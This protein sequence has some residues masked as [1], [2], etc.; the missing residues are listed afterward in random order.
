MARRVA[1][2]TGGGR[3]LGRAIAHALAKD[4]MAVAVGA[5]S[6]DQIDD[7]ASELRAH[8]HATL[9]VPL[10]VTDAGSNTAAVAAVIRALGPIDIL[11]NTA[12]IAESAPFGRTTGCK[13]SST[14]VRANWPSRRARLWWPAP[15]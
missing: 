8:G 10:D 2:V 5:R 13:Y 14:S 3:G 4:G 1:L 12:G 7:V 9:A 15:R 11:V 6:R